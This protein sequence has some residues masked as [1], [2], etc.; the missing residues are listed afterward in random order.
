MV[1]LGDLCPGSFGTHIQGV[2]FSSVLSFSDAIKP[3][4]VCST[5]LIPKAEGKLHHRTW[6]V[7]FSLPP[8]DKF[9]LVE[10]ICYY[11]CGI[12]ASPIDFLKL[13]SI[14]S[15]LPSCRFTYSLPPGENA[16]KTGGN[17]NLLRGDS[18]Y[19]HVNQRGGKKR[20]LLKWSNLTAIIF[21]PQN[22]SCDDFDRKCNATLFDLPARYRSQSEKT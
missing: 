13:H 3:V 14:A 6:F 21:Q 10:E 5:Q 9:V 11:F 22:I 12:A 7:N 18:L 16:L 17:R 20:H 19:P 8:Q 1:L 2:V 4:S 15:V